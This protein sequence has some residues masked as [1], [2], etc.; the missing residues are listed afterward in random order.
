MTMATGERKIVSTLVL[1][2]C[3][4]VALGPRGVRDQSKRRISAPVSPPPAGQAA[5]STAAP[6]RSREDLETFTRMILLW[7]RWI[8]NPVGPDKDIRAVA[9]TICL[10]YTSDAADDLLCVDLGGRRI[11]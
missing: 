6:I 9:L 11:I 5:G 7:R 8:I 4:Q 1:R 3:G 10:L 2:L